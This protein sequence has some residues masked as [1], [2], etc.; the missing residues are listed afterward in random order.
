M[1]M[2]R[3]L[4]G[5]LTCLSAMLMLSACA[6]AAAPMKG[7]PLRVCADPN[8]LP[9]SN[10]QGQGFENK[11]AELVGHA[12]GRPV[13]YVWSSYRQKGGFEN[14]LALNLDVHPPRCD[15]IMNLPYGDSEETFT[16]PYYGST[17]V[18]VY[19]KSKH[20]NFSQ[21]MDAPILSHIKIGFEMGTPVVAGL[22]MRGLVLTATHFDTA[23]SP[24]A[25]PKTPLEAVKDGKIDVLITWEPLVGYFVQKDFPN[26][27]MT[28]V[29]DTNSM[30]T[31]E[32]YLFFMSMG[33]AKGEQTLKRQ[34]NHVI[35]T[36]K[37]QIKKILTSYNVR[38]LH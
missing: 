8:Y 4:T 17:Y 21:G 22:Q 32:R 2:K 29:P 26:L 18:F 15:M 27:T 16:K 35:T 37:A 5:V 11:V 30:G 33:V 19:K 31:P 20:Y 25:S 14:F 23:G 24:T 36:H 7:K 6:R 3:A 1:S 38:I 10:K 12:L 28:R 34:L 9:Y 13:K